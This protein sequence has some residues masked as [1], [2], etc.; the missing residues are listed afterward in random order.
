[1]DHRRCERKRLRRSKASKS[2]SQ[3]PDLLPRRGEGLLGRLGPLDGGISLIHQPQG[4]FPQFSDGH[5]HKFVYG[6]LHFV[7]FLFFA[8]ASRWAL[9]YPAFH[10]SRE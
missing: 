9:S 5:L 6:C 1:M 8:R 7:T 2:T 3:P 10:A 4:R